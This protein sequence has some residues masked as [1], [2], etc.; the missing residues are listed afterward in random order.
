MHSDWD[1]A[2]HWAEGYASDTHSPFNG[3]D[4]LAEPE[5]RWPAWL[6]EWDRRA[7]PDASDVATYSNVL[8][9]IFIGPIRDSFKRDTNRL[10]FGSPPNEYRTP[11][12]T[13]ARYQERQA[14]RARR[15][16]EA[17]SEPVP[18]SAWARIP[19]RIDRAVNGW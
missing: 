18:T 17:A 10:L 14:R 7:R 2:D 1:Q 8:R 19:I 11:A 3:M 12:A 6:A 16:V 9:D 15:R 13:L 4:M 5:P